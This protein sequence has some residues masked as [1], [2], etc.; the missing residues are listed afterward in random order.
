MVQKKLP[1]SDRTANRRDWVQ[2]FRG[3]EGGGI[4]RETEARNSAVEREEIEGNI[5]ESTGRKF[6][7][8]DYGG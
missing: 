5:K 4:K 1:T 8:S 3:D 2:K 7:H 6:V